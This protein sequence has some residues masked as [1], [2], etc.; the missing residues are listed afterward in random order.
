MV[1][2]F[3]CYFSHRRWYFLRIGKLGSLFR[4]RIDNVSFLLKRRPYFRIPQMLVV[5]RFSFLPRPFCLIQWIITEIIVGDVDWLPFIVSLVTFSSSR[6]KLLICLILLRSDELFGVRGPYWFVFI[7]SSSFI[8]VVISF[9]AAWCWCTLF[10]SH[11]V[12]V[13]MFL[14]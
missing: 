13:W 1:W 8:E 6:I 2:N 14:D 10:N 11:F 12:N 3:H 9:G 5:I 7:V 4:T